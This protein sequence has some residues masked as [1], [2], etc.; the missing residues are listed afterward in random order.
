M[1]ALSL[2]STFVQYFALVKSKTNCQHLTYIK[3][4]KSRYFHNV[5]TVQPFTEFYA[6]SFPDKPSSAE[7]LVVSVALSTIIPA[8]FCVLSCIVITT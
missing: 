5:L 1:T 2:K 3:T 4:S 7:P 6:L 8:V